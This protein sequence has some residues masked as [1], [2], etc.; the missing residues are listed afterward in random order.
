MSIGAADPALVRRTFQ[1]HDSVAVI[2][3]DEFDRLED[4]E[5]VQRMADTI[6]GLDGLLRQATLD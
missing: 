3:I 4:R 2:I 5:T 6:K 1:A